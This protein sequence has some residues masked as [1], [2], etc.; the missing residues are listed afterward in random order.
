M[1]GPLQISKEKG[2]SALDHQELDSANN[3]N[4][5]EHG[6]FPKLPGKRPAC[7]TPQLWPGEIHP[8]EGS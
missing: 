2:T 6:F 3:L 7:L 8:K 4:A 5:L 1:D